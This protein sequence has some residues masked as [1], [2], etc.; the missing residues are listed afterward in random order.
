MPK[1]SIIMAIVARRSTMTLVIAMMQKLSKTRRIIAAALNESQTMK[2]FV[3]NETIV[4]I[5][6]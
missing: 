2:R 1:R 4:G 3:I 5:M 6:P